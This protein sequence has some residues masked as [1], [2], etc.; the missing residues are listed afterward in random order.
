MFTRKSWF[1]FGSTTR[2]VPKLQCVQNIGYS[3]HTAVTLLEAYN[4]YDIETAVLE[5]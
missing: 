2:R 1:Y 4:K 5:K 3:V